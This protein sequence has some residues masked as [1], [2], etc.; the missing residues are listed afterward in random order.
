M[1]SKFSFVLLSACVHV[2]RVLARLLG[3]QTVFL[4]FAGAY[5]LY[6]CV[7]AYVCVE[8]KKINGDLHGVSER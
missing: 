7:H 3:L 4:I 6:L 5:V 1:L 8:L 2:R